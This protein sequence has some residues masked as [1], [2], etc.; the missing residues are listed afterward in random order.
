MS[1]T[2]SI[3]QPKALVGPENGKLKSCFTSKVLI[4]IAHLYDHY[5][6]T[7]SLSDHEYQ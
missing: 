2:A 1:F 7:F 5:I 4:S 3:E 6:K